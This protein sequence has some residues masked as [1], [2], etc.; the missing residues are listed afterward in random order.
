MAH[1]EHFTRGDCTG[2]T[3][4]VER[5]KDKNGNYLKYKNGQID[6]SRSHLNY[7]LAPE[8]EETQLEF[9]RQRTDELNAL[10]RK[11]VNVLGSW[12]V[13][14]P[15]TVPQEYQKE[16]FKTTYGHLTDMYGEKNVV[17]A[18]VHMDE[19]TPHMHFCFVPVVYDAKKQR[20]KV[21]CKEC[22]TQIDLKKFHPAL[23][24]SLD[25]WRKN[26][27]YTFE[28]DIQNGATAG[29]NM[30]V[31]ELKARTLEEENNKLSRDNEWL[32][33]NINNLHIEVDNL[34]ERSDVAQ[35]R[36]N[37]LEGINQRLK[38]E[39]DVLSHSVS[40]Q[41][42][43]LNELTPKLLKA[44]EIKA[45]KVDKGLFGKQKETVTLNYSDYNNLLQ[46]AT[47]VEDVQKAKKELEE[48]EK[49]IKEKEY[50]ASI[51]LK[52]SRVQLENAEKVQQSADNL[53]CALNEIYADAEKNAN[54]LY[55]R[56]I[57]SR[58][59]EDEL[60]KFK[61][62]ERQ[63]QQKKYEKLMR[64]LGWQQLEHDE[65]GNDYTPYY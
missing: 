7:N 29:G 49:A 45:Q 64:K 33:K 23:Q 22:V 39:N 35:E 46:T 15:Q 2:M 36:L 34:V 55:I 3:Q 8:R 38:S 21:S 63:M 24:K 1:F 42:E 54:A 32:K 51:N 19:T 57:K 12:I 30:T 6:T 58:H 13:T 31:Q 62:E 53:R 59:L 18:Y 60:K 10:K 50:N 41:R 52:K 17:S 25:D 28:C 5:K 27:G 44:K 61:D 47:V 20:E 11:D 40:S 4:H 48:R 56:F 16:F 26:N 65:K 9:I 37:N 43:E 14:V